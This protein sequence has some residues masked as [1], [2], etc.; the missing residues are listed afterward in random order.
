M[1]VT[2]SKVLASRLRV[3]R[4]EADMTQG[5]LARR[6]GVSQAAVSSWESGTRQP[7]VDDLYAI[8]DELE[9]EVYDLL[10]RRAGPPVRITLRAVADQL[11][12]GHLGLALEEFADKAE[13]LPRDQRQ[14]WSKAAGSVEAAAELLDELGVT[15]PPVD[16]DAVARSCGIPVL[17]FDFDDALSGL[18]VEM[19]EGPVI[20]VNLHHPPTRQRFSIA[21]EL[22]H[23]LL[24]HIDT[25]HVDLGM[26]AEDGDPPGYNWRHERAANEFAANLLMPATMIKRA[27][28][29]TSG[30]APLARRFEVSE[31]AM[32]FRLRTLELT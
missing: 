6:L 31:L 30:I 8:A 23:V 28:E 14:I 2:P 25:F 9:I 21:H 4:D 7:G 17:P 32:G 15:K 16:V 11:E 13:S 3:A 12:R 1:T 19:E 10:P 20:G 24:R 18:V 26:A 29:K 22:G 27:F 5:E